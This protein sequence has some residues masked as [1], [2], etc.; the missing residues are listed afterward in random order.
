MS[1]EELEK[2][3]KKFIND[4]ALSAVLSSYNYAKAKE[5]AKEIEKNG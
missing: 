4:I 3:M 5:L 1:K 2:E